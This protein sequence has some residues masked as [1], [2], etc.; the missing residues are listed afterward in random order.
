QEPI[1]TPVVDEDG[2]LRLEWDISELDEGTYTLAVEVVDSLERA[3][4]S[5]AVEVTIE[6]IRPEPPTAAEDTP[7]PT[8][9]PVSAFPAALA[10]LQENPAGLLLAGLGGVFLV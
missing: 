10:R 3:T 7:T 8:A 6:V 2:R 9:T 4:R 5:E 1:E